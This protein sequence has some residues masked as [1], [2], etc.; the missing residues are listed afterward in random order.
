MTVCKGQTPSSTSSLTLHINMLLRKAN[1][2]RL[3]RTQNHTISDLLLPITRLFAV[4]CPESADSWQY[5]GPKNAFDWFLPI[6]SLPDFP[7]SQTK[8]YKI[9]SRGGRKSCEKSICCLH[10]PLCTQAHNMHK[11]SCKN[12]ELLSNN[13]SLMTSKSAWYLAYFFLECPNS[14]RFSF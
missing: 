7:E 8:N 9:H 10:C 14:V 2:F 5:V 13:I 6:F 12:I 11:D 4:L 1:S 3:A